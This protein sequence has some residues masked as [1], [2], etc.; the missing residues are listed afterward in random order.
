MN[1]YRTK[2]FARCPAND[3]IIDYSLAIHTGTMIRVEEI[4][5]ELAEIKSGYHEDIADR[6]CARFGG[7]QTI[8][9]TH[10]GVDIET[11]RPHIAHW[12]AAAIAQ[13]SAQEV[14]P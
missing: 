8:K 2:F 12:A 5:A 14:K 4:N 1:I 9:A 3:C 13:G 10:H 7:S 6:L 11:I